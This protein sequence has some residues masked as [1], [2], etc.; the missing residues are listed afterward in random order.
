MKITKK[1]GLFYLDPETK[2]DKEYFKNLITIIHNL[3]ISVGRIPMISTL[4][5]KMAKK[6]SKK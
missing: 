4:D 6:K 5:R 2:T 1:K 3:D